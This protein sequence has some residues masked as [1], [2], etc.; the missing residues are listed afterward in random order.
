MNRKNEHPI[1]SPDQ[2]ALP[3]LEEDICVHIFTTSAV[4]LGVCMT[5][6]GVLH[7][8]TV[9]RNVDVVGDDI[10]SINSIVYLAACL[11]AYWALRTR[12]KKRNHLLERTADWLFLAGLILSAT[13]TGLIT[14]TIAAS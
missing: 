12:S 14:W 10:L 7:V 1:S 6:V 3:S 8:V 13:A 4:M 2:G 5:V 11:S 9:L